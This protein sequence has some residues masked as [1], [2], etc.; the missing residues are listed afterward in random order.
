VAQRDKIKRAA[1]PPLVKLERRRD[2]RAA[3]GLVLI[4]AAAFVAYFPSLRGGFILDDDMLLTAKPL[5]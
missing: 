5:L 3:A 1:R 4:I 2:R